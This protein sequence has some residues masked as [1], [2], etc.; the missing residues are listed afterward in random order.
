M[1]NAY[2]RHKRRWQQKGGVDSDIYLNQATETFEELVDDNLNPTTHTVEYTRPFEF[3]INNKY[4][5]NIVISDVTRNANDKYDTKLL[6]V[7]NDSDIDSSSYIWWNNDVWIVS[8]E[9]NNS[10]LTHRTYNLKKCS[11]EIKIL[12]DGD[13]FTY[14]IALTNLTIYSD[15]LKENLNI[16]TSS[17][18]YSILLPSNDITD[19]VEIETRFLINGKAFKVTMVDNFTNKNVHT[20][21][22]IE[23]SLN[24]LDD[25]E[26][27]VAWNSNSAIEEITDY[28][29]IL[30][31]DIIH[32]G[33]TLE[34]T[35]TDAYTWN[36]I[37]ESECVREIVPN[38]GRCLIS[39]K[40]NNNLINEKIIVQ[41]INVGGAIIR[42]KE[43]I[44]RGLF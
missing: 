20:L 24:S 41:A 27:N 13:L 44:V 43:I 35:C 18:K 31:S 11:E 3:D 40:S 42:E 12:I 14:P 25:V 29:E 32:L 39:C 22:V 1:T 7:R 21:T 4:E 6:H 2:S 33:E 34:L 16:T 5:A 28:N 10:V 9:E 26:N 30:G 36:I 19:M 8:N 15:G 23:V 17:V 37:D 38:S